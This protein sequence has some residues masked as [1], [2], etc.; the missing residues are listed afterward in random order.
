MYCQQ[1][2]AQNPDSS[3]F[4]R[5]CG[6]SMGHIQQPSTDYSPMPH[7]GERRQPYPSEQPLLSVLGTVAMWFGIG[8]FTLFVI[9]MVLARAVGLVEL[10]VVLIASCI[11]VG[12]GLVLRYLSRVAGERNRIQPSGEDTA[13]LSAG[14]GNKSFSLGASSTTPLS[15]VTEATTELLDA[16][17]GGRVGM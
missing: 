15:S 9:Y 17:K 2:S 13:N 10:L 11:A 1:C 7:P 5:V 4:C 16:K 6:A 3:K 12:L 14:A 8:I